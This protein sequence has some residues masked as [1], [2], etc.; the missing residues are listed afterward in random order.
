MAR[1]LIY[2]TPIA[3]IVRLFSMSAIN[4][5]LT[6]WALA[7]IG[8]NDIRMLLPA[9]IFVASILTISYHTTLRN[10]KVSREVSPAIY[11]VC[12]ASFCSMWMLLY[13]NHV[14]STSPVCLVPNL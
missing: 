12:F 6:S 13:E 2:Y 1:W 3:T 10:I 8:T 14:C 7:L 4:A 11:I 5:Y 9:W